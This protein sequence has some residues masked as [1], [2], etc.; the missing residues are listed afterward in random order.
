MKTSRNYRYIKKKI[1][2]QSTPVYYNNYL[3]IPSKC[4]Y[5]FFVDLY[6]TDAVHFKIFMPVVKFVLHKNGIY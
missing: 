1:K 5:L 4:I 3:I 2:N 6:L